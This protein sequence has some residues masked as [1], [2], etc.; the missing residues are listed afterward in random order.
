MTSKKGMPPHYICEYCDFISSN[1]DDIEI[2]HVL[3]KKNKVEPVTR[4]KMPE[5]PKKVGVN[6]HKA[7]LI[8]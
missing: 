8:R 3:P 5:Q 7:I 6:N 1:R 4:T 2:D